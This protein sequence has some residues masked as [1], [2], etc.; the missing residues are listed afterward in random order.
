[1]FQALFSIIIITMAIS[2]PYV[3]M[4]TILSFTKIHL[5][6]TAQ[7]QFL[8]IIYGLIVSISS[9]FLACYL[10]S[11]VSWKTPF[12]YLFKPDMLK[13]MSRENIYN[14]LDT[15]GEIVACHFLFV[16]LICASSSLI[17]FI[18]IKFKCGRNFLTNLGLINRT[19]QLIRFGDFNKGLFQIDISQD[20]GTVFTGEFEEW[21]D[22]GSAK[23]VL[24]NNVY[25][26]IVPRNQSIKPY[27]AYKQ[28]TAPEINYSIGELNEMFFPENTIK[29][30]HFRSYKRPDV[31]AKEFEKR[32]RKKLASTGNE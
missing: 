25:K 20:D 4:K 22:N 11:S 14:R 13:N 31:E 23:G 21:S 2:A 9:Y 12:V 28:E 30:I 27:S 1:M 18:I 7:K 8:S 29:N 15:W 10:N 6:Q 24:L 32:L 19:N 17:I 5:V 3:V 16:T 26:T